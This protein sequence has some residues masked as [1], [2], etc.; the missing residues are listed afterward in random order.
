MC[1]S[2]DPEQMLTAY[3]CTH[4]PLGVLPHATPTKTKPRLLVFCRSCARSCS[5]R[6]HGG[7][8]GLMAIVGAAGHGGLAV[9]ALLVLRGLA[10]KEEG[11]GLT[12]SQTMLDDV[13][14]WMKDTLSGATAGY[15]PT[16]KHWWFRPVVHL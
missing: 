10:G 2:L 9:M 13:T 5:V 11:G 4:S 6:G 1:R 14:N 16:L 12:F 8:C 15:F 7:S 3:A